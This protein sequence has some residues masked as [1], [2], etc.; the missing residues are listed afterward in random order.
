MFKPTKMI[1]KIGNEDHHRDQ[2]RRR[3][4]LLTRNEEAEAEKE[5]DTDT[6]QADTND[7]FIILLKLISLNQ[8]GLLLCLP[9]FT[10]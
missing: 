7:M 6:V 5:S 2:R 4:N 3:A 10:N 9:L 8:Y 1:K